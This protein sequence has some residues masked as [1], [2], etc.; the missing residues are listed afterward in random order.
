MSLDVRTRLTGVTYPSPSQI[1]IPHASML[2]ILI[3]YLLPLPSKN[4]TYPH[5]ALFT[6]GATVVIKA[7]FSEKWC[8]FGDAWA[9][10]SSYHDPRK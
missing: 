2:D 4:H 8:T 6:S 7:L 1:L 5:K 9:E 10:K 3:E